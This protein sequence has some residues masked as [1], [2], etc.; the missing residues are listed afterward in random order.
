[1]GDTEIASIIDVSDFLKRFKGE[2]A[3]SGIDFVPRKG[4][5]DALAQLGITIPD[6]EN[7]LLGL[8]ATDYVSGPE[9]DHNGSP[10]EIWVFGTMIHRRQIYIKVKLDTGRAACLSFHEAQYPLRFPL[11]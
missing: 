11:R 7:T 10:G 8:S 4:Y 9:S 5:L 3:L 2:S 1:M 6:A